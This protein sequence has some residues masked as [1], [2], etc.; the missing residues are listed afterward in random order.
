MRVG[1]YMSTYSGVKFYP[2]DPRVEEIKTKDISHALSMTCRANG[3]SRHFYSV[4]QHSLNCAHEAAGRGHSRRV[5]L[6]CLLHDASEAYISDIIRPVKSELEEYLA[7]ESRLQQ[8]IFRAYGLA[9]LSEEEH[10][11]INQVDDCLLDYEH[12]ELLNGS[13][14]KTDA[15][16]E[17]YDLSFRPMEDVRDEFIQVV[18][19]LSLE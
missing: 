11:L 5:Q 18:D 12:G 3:H 2:L 15:L 6:G 4:A 1:N 9:D 14:K 10:L 16:V 19:R 7:V 8:T 17:M 13:P